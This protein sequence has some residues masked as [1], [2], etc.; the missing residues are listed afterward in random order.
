MSAVPE[1]RRIAINLPADCQP[2][3]NEWRR[4][5]WARRHRHQGYVS[6][7]V[8]IAALQ[9][10]WRGGP[11]ERAVVSVT[12]HLPPGPR[13]DPDNYSPKFILDGLRAAAII[14]DDDARHITLDVRIG[15]PR[16]PGEIA[17]MV[18]E[19]EM[20]MTGRKETEEVSR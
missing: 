8:T 16:R 18:E 14:R 19:R 6:D 11:M 17:V 9:A 7:L 3:L 20:E 13:R 10:L 15:E 2:S 4:W 1:L 5:H 12:Y